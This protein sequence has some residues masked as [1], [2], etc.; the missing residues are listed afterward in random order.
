MQNVVRNY[1]KPKNYKE[2]LISEQ[3]QEL[4]DYQKTQNEIFLFLFSIGL[5]KLLILLVL[6]FNLFINFLFNK[7]ILSIN[8]LR[9]RLTFIAIF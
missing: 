2:S 8:G 1:S 6:I 5:D 9:V 7:F 4:D 3:R